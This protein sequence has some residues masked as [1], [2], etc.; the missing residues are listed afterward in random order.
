MSPLPD[1]LRSAVRALVRRPG[2]T[3]VAVGTVALAIAANT[4]TFSVVNGVLLRPL[5]FRNA[6]RLA[7]MDVRASS[8][9]LISLSIPNYR[10]W[11]DQNRV[12]DAFAAS[13]GWGFTLTGRGP[14]QRI[15]ARAVMGDFFGTLGLTPH[16]GRLLTADESPARPGAERLVVLSHAFWRQQFGGDP[17]AIGQTLTLSGQPFTI[18]G[19]LPR[20]VGFPSPNVELYVPMGFEEDLPWEDRGSSFGTRAFARLAPGVTVEAARG[21]LA[22]VGNQLREE[23]GPEAAQPEVRALDEFYAGDVSAQLW[24]LMGAVGFVLLIAVANVGNLLLARGEDRQRELAVRTALGAGRGAIFRLLL[25]EAMVIAGA[26]GV[27][28]AAL[29]IPAVRGLGRM[30]PTDLP[31]LLA[32][33]VRV[34]LVALAFAVGLALTA[35]VLFGVA[36]ALRAARGSLGGALVTGM[37]A[38]GAGRLRSALVVAEVAL[39]LVLLVG[40]GLMLRSLGNL[41][42]VEKGFDAEQVLTAAVAISPGRSETKEQWLAYYQEVETRAAALPGVRAA[43]VALLLPLGDRSWELRIYPE[44]VPITR[45]SGQS[46]LYNVVSTDYFEALR[47]PI[48]RGRSFTPADR[49]GTDPVTVI[50]ETM[51]ERF[52]PGEDPIGKRVTFDVDSVGAPIYRTVV[53]VAANVRH[54][55]LETPSRIQAYVPFAQSL[56]RSGMSLRLILA[57]GMPAAQLAGSL[58]A[59]VT[60]IDPDAPVSDVRPLRE[61]VAQAMATDQAMSRVLAAFGAAALALAALGIFGVMSYAVSRRT[62]EIGIR[63]ALGAAATDVFAWVGGN[64]LRLTMFGV[65]LGVAA[66]MGLTRLLRRILFEVSPLDPVVFGAVALILSAVALLAAYLPARRATRVD[67]V[68]VLNVE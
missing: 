57:T 53:G 24:I 40:G 16:A 20:G 35:G 65:V 61:F 10:D 14:A 34:D 38:T 62:R 52:W 39:A 60:E 29:T 30:L 9:Y 50:D 67:P 47:V 64:A 8:G 15:V 41:R 58:R 3:A 27:L 33:Q 22:R 25:T 37:R 31:A 6:D 4:A 63:M 45:E 28:G 7:T 36:P 13:A 23:H 56:G 21:D 42:N 17:G 55:E 18:V 2:F 32:A 19:V 5:P 43:A 48:V 11:G 59:L 1:H 46:V 44:G 66:A 54:Y 68:T 12:F 49:D 51:A 26:G